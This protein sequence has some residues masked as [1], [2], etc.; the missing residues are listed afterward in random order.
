MARQKVLADRDGEIGDR[1]PPE[2]ESAADDYDK[3]YSATIKAREKRDAAKLTLIE[4]MKAT[5]CKR[6]PIRGGAKFLELE[7][8]D[9]IKHTKPK[10]NPAAQINGEGGDV[11]MKRGR[12]GRMTTVHRPATTSVVKG[13]KGAAMPMASLVP[14]GLTAKKAESL[15]AAFGKTIGHLEKAMRENEYWH[16]DVKGMGEEWITK[17][18]D[19]LLAFR[20]E[21]PVPSEDDAPTV[22]EAAGK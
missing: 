18:I 10:E 11:V 16:R 22:L 13:D 17:T 12:G 14:H 5:G 1:I 2:V 3:H 21:H 20:K 9:K 8:V 15:A 7:E 4:K 19:A 6:C